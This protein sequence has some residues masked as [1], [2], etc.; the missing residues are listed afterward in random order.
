M[1]KD[2]I[3]GRS[4]QQSLISIGLSD[5]IAQAV[6]LMKKYDIEHIPVLEKG[7]PVGS[8]S[9]AGLFLKIFSNPEIRSQKV[10]EVIED[11]FPVVSFEA[12]IERIAKLI[13]KDT[14]AVIAKDETGSYHIIT[15]YDIIQNFK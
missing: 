13:K 11:A 6:E 14:G 8:I 12:P 10:S 3:S 2:I 5:T 7:E 9:E 4:N 1:L 15:K